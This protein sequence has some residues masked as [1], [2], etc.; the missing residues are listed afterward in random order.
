IRTGGVELPPA[1]AAAWGARIF[2]AAAGS[3]DYT[4]F[5]IATAMAL[6]AFAEAA[7]DVAVVEVGLG[8]R[9]DATNVVAQPLATIVTSVA[10]DHTDVLGDTLAAIAREKAGIWKP[11]VPAIFACDD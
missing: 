7:V 8:G 5:E 6:A 1:A 4:F 10:L 11:G 2:A 9:L 3:G